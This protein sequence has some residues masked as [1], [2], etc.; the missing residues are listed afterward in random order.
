VPPRQRQQLLLQVLL[1]GDALLPGG[2]LK[3]GAPS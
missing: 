2:L 3:R 1:Q